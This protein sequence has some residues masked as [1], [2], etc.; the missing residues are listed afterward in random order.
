MLMFMFLCGS[1]FSTHL[2]KCQIAFIYFWLKNN[3]VNILFN[4]MRGLVRCHSWFKEELS[5]HIYRPPRVLNELIIRCKL[6]QY[7]LQYQLQFYWHNLYFYEW[8]S[9]ILLTVFYHSQS[10]KVA[11][12]QPKSDIIQKWALDRTPVTV[13][14]HF[15]DFPG[16]IKM[17]QVKGVHL[18]SHKRSS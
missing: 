6:G 4:S 12:R 18:L 15:T 9:F 14:V 2:D 10:C 8:K 17:K 3:I 11:Q 16:E 5:I 1:E 7:L 13:F